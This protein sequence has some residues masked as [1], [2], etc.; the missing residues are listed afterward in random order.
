MEDGQPRRFLCRLAV[1]QTNMSKHD[2]Y[3]L[4]P[5]FYDSGGSGGAYWQQPDA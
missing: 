2:R 4:F 1:P 3:D 5:Q